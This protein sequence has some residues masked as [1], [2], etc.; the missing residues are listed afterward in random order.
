[1]KIAAT[2]NQSVAA[3]LRVRNKPHLVDSPLHEFYFR[4]TPEL[5]DFCLVEHVLKKRELIGLLR[6]RKHHTPIR[7]EALRRGIAE[8]Q[9]RRRFRRLHRFADSLSGLYLL[10]FQR[11]AAMKALADL[12]RML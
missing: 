3:H 9:E 8:T 10:C 2:K 1:V 6:R 4:H 12:T 11:T 5:R 7:P